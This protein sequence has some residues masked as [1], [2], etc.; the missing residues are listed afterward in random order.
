MAL[1][2]AAKAGFFLR[3]RRQRQDAGGRA[4]ALADALHQACNVGGGFHC[5]QRCGHGPGFYHVR[6]KGGEPRF[7]PVVAGVNA[8]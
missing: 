2:M 7:C 5:F 1:A 8:G 6:P 3:R 4:R